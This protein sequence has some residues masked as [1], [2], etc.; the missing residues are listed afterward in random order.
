MNGLVECLVAPKKKLPTS[1][2]PFDYR[3]MQD[4]GIR[5]FREHMVQG[6]KHGVVEFRRM[7]GEIK[8]E[9]IYDSDNKH[10]H[11][12]PKK[13]IPD[14]RY[15]DGIY[16]SFPAWFILL[17]GI[18]VFMM[19]LKALGFVL[20][21][22]DLGKGGW[23]PGKAVVEGMTDLQRDLLGIGD[24]RAL[25]VEQEAEVCRFYYDRG[26]TIDEVPGGPQRVFC[27]PYFEK[28]DKEQEV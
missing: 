23:Y 1:N 26:L 19:I 18:P 15:P 6:L 27:R 21:G 17:I 9:R 2:A 28:W 16:Y 20:P 22:F 25:D 3:D 4:V 24:V 12:S 11:L 10:F 14:P 5:G 7:P 8:R 13:F